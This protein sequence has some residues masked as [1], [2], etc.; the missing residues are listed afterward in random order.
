VIKAGKPKREKMGQLVWVPVSFP[1][2]TSWEGAG[3]GLFL[4]G[5][6]KNRTKKTN[7]KTRW[8][9]AS[10]ERRF[11]KTKGPKKRGAKMTAK[12]EK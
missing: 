8:N 10:P 3:E 5:G 11:G 7:R 9:N 1:E 12:K 6:E 2:E 4:V